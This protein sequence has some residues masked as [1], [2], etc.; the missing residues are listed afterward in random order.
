MP[1]VSIIVPVYN[2]ELYLDKCIQSIINQTYNDIEIILINDGSTDNSGTKC[3][4]WAQ[5]DSRIKYLQKKNEGLGPTRNLGIMLA[6]GKYVAFVDSDDWVS[7]DFIEKMI[8]AANEH[9]CDL[10]IC[11]Y[12]KFDND[13]GICT[14]KHNY[15]NTESGIVSKYDVLSMQD[16][17]IWR[18]LCKKN[19][20]INNEILMPALPYEDLAVFAFLVSNCEKITYIDKPLYYYRTKREGSIMQDYTKRLY[21]ADVLKYLCNYF[22]RNGSFAEY[23][24]IL[25]RISV[26]QI[27]YTFRS[28]N[29]KVDESVLKKINN[30]LSTFMDAY[31]PDCNLHKFNFIVLGSYNLYRTILYCTLNTMNLDYYGFSSL[32]SIMSEKIDISYTQSNRF[33]EEMIDK[34]LQKTLVKKLKNMNDG[35]IAID[36]LEERFDII[37][38]KNTYITS[39]DAFEESIDTKFVK[40]YRNSDEVNQLWKEK[41]MQFITLL[42]KYVPPDRIILVKMKLSKYYGEHGKENVFNNISYIERINSILDDYYNFFEK[43]MKGIKIIDV[44]DDELFYTNKYFP[45][46]CYPYHLNNEFYYKLSKK[47]NL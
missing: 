36:F 4:K 12:Y 42:K 17:S 18:V 47:F 2:V 1:E 10:V 41:C 14:T 11:N 13:T 25:K 40:L 45:H 38:Y 32:I 5:A 35:Y 28:I 20:F 43:H 31:F 22:I 16:T 21:M 3:E 9:D 33:R 26:N 34:D 15:L 8:K 29:N 6:S 30:D 37:K 39:S 46:G 23:Y 24:E 7:H 19:I 27:L 44:F